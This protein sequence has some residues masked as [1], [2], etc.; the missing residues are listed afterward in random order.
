MMFRKFARRASLAPLAAAATIAVGLLASSGSP[1]VAAVGRAPSQPPT[2][3]AIVVSS[4]IIRSM[5]ESASKV[6]VIKPT[7]A[8]TGIPTFHV[9][10]AGTLAGIHACLSLGSDG[11][12]QGVECADLYAAPDGNGG[13]DVFPEAEGF[14]NHG[15]SYPQCANVDILLN[16]NLGTGAAG[17]TDEGVCGHSHGDCVKNNRNFFIGNDGFD[18][19]GCGGVGT[20]SEVWTVDWTGSVIELP[21]SGMNVTSTSNLGSGHALVCP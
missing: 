12:N 14:C 15:T 10:S 6:K 19:T 2:A 1:A 11:T 18:L 7:V 16:V 13:V 20:S 4:H 3:R 5:P 9:T 8:A 21:T 17:T